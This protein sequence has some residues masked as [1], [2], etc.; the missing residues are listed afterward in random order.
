MRLIAVSGM[1]ASGKTTLARNLARLLGWR[2]APESA[3]G[4]AFLRD[5]F[6]NPQRWAFDAQ[7]SFLSEKA[8]ALQ[9]L[10]NSGLNVVLDRTIEEDIEI[11]ARHF[12]ALGCI[13]KRSFDTY[14]SIY[15][16]FESI[17]PPPDIQ[18]HC[19][20]PL[21]TIKARL[22]LRARE[23]DKLYPPN[24]IETMHAKYE[25]WAQSRVGAKMLAV[26]TSRI[27]FRLRE[28]TIGL[29]ERINKI[30]ETEEAI[31]QFSLFDDLEMPTASQPAQR[32]RRG[33]FLPR[34]PVSVLIGTQ[35]SIENA[36]PKFPYA[37]I[38]APFSALADAEPESVSDDN[39]G[40][41]PTE[42][43]HGEIRRGWY[44]KNLLR[45]AAELEQLGLH[46]VLPHRDVNDWGKKLL[47]SSQVFESCTDHVRNCDAFV[48]ILGQSPG[49]HYE[50]GLAAALGKPSIVIHCEQLNPSY[51]SLGIANA[52]TL[53]LRCKT[54]SAAPALIR[55]D[56]A[57]DFLT[58]TVAGLL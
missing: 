41:F 32:G 54:L 11:F 13:D 16:N 3:R 12:Y 19:H 45:I 31:E 53:I 21:N 2:Y 50:F 20:A 38:A 55:S 52:T 24:H 5:M 7:L 58:T 36:A 6:A 39:A 27:D 42:R 29:V 25:S 26:D 48:G 33:Q 43:A 18:V 9:R 35:P 10:L 37:Y 1:M 56:V 15:Q 14:T 44:R 8:I 22:K 57:K 40:L 47:Q 4:T 23:T 51:I 34:S 17:L 49:S 46:S 28:P 30:T